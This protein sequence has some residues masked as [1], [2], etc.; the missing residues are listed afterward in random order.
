MRRKM[1]FLFVVVV[2]LVVSSRQAFSEEVHG[3]VTDP[4]GAVI[5]GAIVR[6]HS[7]GRVIVSAKTDERGRYALQIEHREV[8]AG[9]MRIRITAPAFAASD[10]PVD[11][12]QSPRVDLSIRLEIAA[13]SEQVHVEA[14]SLP[15]ADQLDMSEVRESSAK[16]VGEALTSV[17]G[18]YKIRKAAI[19]NDVVVRGFQQNNVNL[20]IDGAR[21]YGACPGHMDP[22]A[23]HVDFAEVDHVEIVKG[24]FDVSSAGSLG[25]ELRVVTKTPPLGLH[26]TPSLSFGSFNYFN[27][28]ATASFGNSKL[29]VLAG[30]SYRVSDPYKDGS[31]RS[32]LEYANFS[33]AALNRRAFEIHTGW[34]NALWTPADGHKVSLSY[35]RQQNGLVLYPYQSMDSDYDNADRASVK[36]EIRNLSSRVRAIRFESYFTQ[37]VHF[38]SD[39]YRTSARMAMG[40]PWMMAAEPRSRT[41]GGRAEFDAGR[42]LSFGFEGYHRNWNMLGF[43]TMSGMMSASHSLPN[44]DTALVGAFADYRHSFSDRLKLSGGLRFDHSAMSTGIPGLNTDLYF[45]YQNTR[46]TSH[47]DNYGSGNLR[48][49]YSLP[50]QIEFFSGVGVTGRLP[51]ADER[52]LLR[53]SM[54]RPQV[55][56]PSLPAVR[57][58][59]ATAGA[60]YRRGSSYF[61]PTLFFSN[62]DNYILVN[63]QPLLNPT[64]GMSGSARSFTNVDAHIYGGELSYGVGLPAGFSLRGGSSYSR[65]TGARK[66]EAGVSSSALPEMPPFRTWAALRYMHRWGFVEV[67][68]TGAGR[69]GLVDADLNETPTPGYGLLNLKLGILS[70]K[71]TASL[72]V[73]NLLNR[74]Y[75]EN[76]SYYRDPFASGVKVPEPGRNFFAQ[77]K[78]SF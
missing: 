18:I 63:N 2:C 53:P 13:A 8:E 70:R 61:K 52:F 72:V 11:F 38:M 47:T 43:M 3:V 10:S 64:M 42:D 21:I 27:P 36:Y 49:S 67:G 45:A 48:L 4:S 77:V 58:T 35:T 56:N 74:F 69:Q 17:D 60:I 46:G 55:G 65:G 16:D 50:R 73:D 34:F 14:K 31:G 26:F 33:S 5:S 1:L 40:S 44:V 28:A 57:N 59:E 22:A 6:V 32:F 19:A 9:A 62:L 68:G 71:W 29:R 37:V 15:F 39:R 78:C 54:A 7:G 41:A 20:L 30:Y 75:Y 23:Q 76:L 24:A 12:S 66:H 51:D 25:A